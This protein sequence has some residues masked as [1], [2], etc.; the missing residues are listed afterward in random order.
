MLDA[1]YFAY[2]EVK[3]LH[4]KFDAASEYNGFI[5][6]ELAKGSGARPVR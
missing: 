4:D 2:K 3:R 6:V 5:V 1:S